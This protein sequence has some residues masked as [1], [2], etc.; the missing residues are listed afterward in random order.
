MP[1]NVLNSGTPLA[2]GASAPLWTDLCD[3]SSNL[4]NVPAPPPLAIPV[5]DQLVNGV[6]EIQFEVLAPDMIESI[7]I[8]GFIKGKLNDQISLTLKHP[9]YGSFPLMAQHAILGPLSNPYPLPGEIRLFNLGETIPAGYVFKKFVGNSTATQI[10]LPDGQSP[11]DYYYYYYSAAAYEW[12]VKS[13]TPGGA[14]TQITVPAHR[15]PYTPDF[16]YDSV[17]NNALINVTAPIVFRG[18]RYRM[19][20]VGNAEPAIVQTKTFTNLIYDNGPSS[21]TSGYFSTGQQPWQ[22]FN[23]FYDYYYYGTAG[24]AP[25]TEGLYGNYN[26]HDWVVTNVTRAVTTYLV[27]VPPI[28]FYFATRVVDTYTVRFI[29]WAD[30][31]WEV[32]PL[33]QITWESVVPP[34]ALFQF[35]PSDFNDTQAMA[36]RTEPV[37]LLMRQWAGQPAEGTW[38]LEITGASTPIAASGTPSGYNYPPAPT[39]APGIVRIAGMALTINFKTNQPY[40]STPITATAPSAGVMQAICQAQLRAVTDDRAM[41]AILCGIAGSTTMG[42]LCGYALQRVGLTG[43]VYNVTYFIATTCNINHVNLTRRVQ[44]I[45]FD[46]QDWANTATPAGATQ[47]TP[48]TTTTAFSTKGNKGEGFVFH[49]TKHRI[50]PVRGQIGLQVQIQG[51][52]LKFM[53][54]GNYPVLTYQN[55]TV[56]LVNNFQRYSLNA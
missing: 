39:V 25:W 14:S 34:T 36:E 5:P 20:S 11:T 52:T 10:V 1:A 40:L 49:P 16:N 54:L 18:F 37:N 12:Q 2:P 53:L 56:A 45:S 9:V 50:Y 19:L 27:S 15:Y 31:L 55:P 29:R 43:E 7:D 30:I 23:N 26:A 35:Y 8:T 21:G 48:P 41:I 3:S 6:N 13:I 46:A 22:D 44:A 32:D 17:P 4:T 33:A 28:S 38:T 24:N 51:S 42:I 47:P